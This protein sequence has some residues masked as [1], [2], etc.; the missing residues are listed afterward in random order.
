MVG[1]S[2]QEDNLVKINFF[3]SKRTNIATNRK[4]FLEKVGDYFKV[5]IEF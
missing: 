2:M 1:N 4:Q 3:F 5:V